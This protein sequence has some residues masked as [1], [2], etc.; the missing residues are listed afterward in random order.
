MFL[1]DWAMR[2]WGLWAVAQAIMIAM[3]AVAVSA[4]VFWEGNRMLPR[5][6]RETEEEW[7][8]PVD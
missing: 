5:G 4:G 1:N 2:M 7:G 3:A 8:E 6:E